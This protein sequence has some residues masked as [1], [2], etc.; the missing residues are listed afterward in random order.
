MIKVSSKFIERTQK[1][2]IKQCFYTYYSFS[3]NK[4][5]LSDEDNYY[6]WRKI[7]AM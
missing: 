1:F 7:G 3:K 6:F 4:Y 5:A 2:L